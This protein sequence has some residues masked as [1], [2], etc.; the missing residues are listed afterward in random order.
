MFL[1]YRYRLSPTRAQARALRRMLSEQREVYNAA[2]E[3]RIWAYRQGKSLT[4]IEQ[5]KDFAAKNQPEHADWL[6]SRP[7]TYWNGPLV[8]L[9]LAF[10]AFF[11]RVKKGSGKA[12]FPRFKG[13]DG[14]DTI[15]FD[16]TRQRDGVWIDET[17]RTI[18]FKGMP[19]VL[20]ARLDRALP[21]DA[22]I[23]GMR[24]QRVSSG[25]DALYL[26]DIGDGRD[27]VEPKSTVGVDVGLESFATFSDGV[28]IQRVRHEK[29]SRVKVR[30][31]QRALARKKRG[32]VNRRRAK[33]DLARAMRKVANQRDTFHHTASAT[34]VREYDLIAFENLN[35]KGLARGRLAK[36]V[37]DA[38][39][40]RFIF[41]TAYK[42]EKAGKIVLKVDPRH[43]SQA[44]SSCGVM[45]KK[46]LSVRRHVCDCGADLDRDHNAAINILNRALEARRA[47]TGPGGVNGRPLAEPSGSAKSSRR[48]ESGEGPTLGP[49][50][51]SFR[52]N[53][54]R[55]KRNAVTDLR[56]TG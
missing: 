37:N 30:R 11:D 54:P 20:K 14:Y 28:K 50:T 56:L 22:Q 49:E 17:G 45:V 5:R 55:N 38:G 48:P 2:L 23:K 3:Q 35:I 25:W 51:T 6:K 41:Y 16:S 33:A 26:I 43:T 46:S 39:W 21:P 15:C 52:R 53:Q 12:G 44:C 24:F 1:T 8:R 19:G 42:A 29:N 4:L 47:M 7:A 10:K 31:L 32:S 9:D 18:R 34:L 40:A 27:L 13:R 36:S